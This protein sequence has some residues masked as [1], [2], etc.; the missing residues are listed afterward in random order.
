MKRILKGLFLINLVIIL[1]ACSKNYDSITYTKFMEEFNNK[2]EY[3][4]NNQSLR[5]ENQFDRYI[6]AVGN[7][8]QFSYFEFENEEKARTY[9]IDNYKNRKKYSFKDKGK[10]IEVRCTDNMYFRLIQID[11]IVILGNSNLKSNKKEINKLLK[12]LGY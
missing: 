10:Y 5:Y 8:N 1:C 11:K 3:I 4:V 12:E 9:V 6:E 2:K 7:N